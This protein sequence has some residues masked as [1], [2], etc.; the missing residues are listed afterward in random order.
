MEYI[1]MLFNYI[2]EGMQYEVNIFGYDVSLW[3]I[4]I[5]DIVLHV[6]ACFGWGIIHGKD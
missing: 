2:R 6:F 3:G 5:G 4:F 1:Q